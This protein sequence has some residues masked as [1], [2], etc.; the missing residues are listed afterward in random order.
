MS[1]STTGPRA[2][3]RLTEAAFDDALPQWLVQ[4][5]STAVGIPA[6]AVARLTLEQAVDAWATFTAQPRE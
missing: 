4:R 2:S 3:M 5:L 1:S 6:D